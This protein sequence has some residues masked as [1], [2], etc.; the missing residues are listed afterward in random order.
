MQNLDNEIYEQNND[1]VRILKIIEAL[2][3]GCFL[4]PEMVRD[5][6]LRIYKRKDNTIRLIASSIK[7]SKEQIKLLDDYFLSL[8]SDYKDSV[9]INGKILYFDVIEYKGETNN[10]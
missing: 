5:K 2:E 6:F 9:S 4:I 3:K 7:L 10:D 1:S 8:P